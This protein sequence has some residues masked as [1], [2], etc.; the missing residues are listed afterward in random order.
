[1]SEADTRD[2]AAGDTARAALDAA[3]SR[4]PDDQRQAIELAVGA[5]MTYHQ[6]A[7]HVGVPGNVVQQRINRGLQALHVALRDYPQFNGL[8][9]PESDRS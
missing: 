6:I 7:N 4:L 5:R 1:M 8:H 9:N 2:T 3:L